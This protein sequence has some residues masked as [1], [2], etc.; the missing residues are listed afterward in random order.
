MLLKKVPLL[1]LF[2]APGTA[3]IVQSWINHKAK[4]LE[5][6]VDKAMIIDSSQSFNRGRVC[7]Y[8]PTVAR[9]GGWGGGMVL[10]APLPARG[11]FGVGLHESYESISVS[12]CFVPSLSFQFYPSPQSLKIAPS[13]ID[14]WAGL[15]AW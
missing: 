9:W 3:S 14:R 5:R 11:P 8:M 7:A 1:K 10:R 13:D 15:V 4:F 12:N 6:V 2:A